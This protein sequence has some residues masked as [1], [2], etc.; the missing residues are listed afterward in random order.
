MLRGTVLRPALSSRWQRILWAETDA[1]PGPRLRLRT[2]STYSA[3]V[4]FTFF[5]PTS[6]Q[7]QRHPPPPPPPPATGSSPSLLSTH[8]PP[9][10]PAPT[11]SQPSP[12]PTKGWEGSRRR[13]FLKAFSVVFTVFSPWLLRLY[14]H[15]LTQVTQLPDLLILYWNSAV[16][17]CIAT[18]VCVAATLTL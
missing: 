8:P 9:P 5:I 7:Q 6:A 12:T 18:R 16:Y 3:A 13:T 10:P 11:C 15:T 14:S 2:S 4:S 17:F 1:Q